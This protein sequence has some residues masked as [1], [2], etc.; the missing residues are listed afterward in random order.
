MILSSPAGLPGRGVRS[1]GRAT[2]TGLGDPLHLREMHA[3]PVLANEGRDPTGL[4]LPVAEYD[5][6]GPGCE[7]V[8]G[9]YVSRRHVWSPMYGAYF[10]ADYCN[11]MIWGLQQVDGV[12]YSELLFDAAYRISSFG[13][14]E[15][16][17]LY[18]ADPTTDRV[19]RLDAIL[20]DTDGDL[21]PNA[22]EDFYG[23]NPDVP[24]DATDDADKDGPTNRDE[25]FAET[26]PR[27]AASALR[28]VSVGVTVEGLPRV[29]W[30]SVPWKDYRVLA[31]TNIADPWSSI[32]DVVRAVAATTVFIDEALS[33]DR[34][35]YA[36]QTVP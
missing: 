30:A 5:H 9:G 13:E 14:D 8:T 25:F 24:L 32:G 15:E 12:W 3:A 27:S 4:V 23:L 29:A 7:S 33:S 31:R 16:G 10:Y 36:V 11:G 28:I 1:R 22:F 20:P 26:N 21:M 6:S 35:F 19:L 18:L 34:R 2:V 17:N